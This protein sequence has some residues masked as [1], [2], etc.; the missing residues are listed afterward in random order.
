MFPLRT[1]FPTVR[2]TFLLL[3]PPP[4]ENRFKSLV[5]RITPFLKNMGVTPNIGA[6]RFIRVTLTSSCLTFLEEVF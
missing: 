2:I 5:S 6:R 4:V 1:T 3:L